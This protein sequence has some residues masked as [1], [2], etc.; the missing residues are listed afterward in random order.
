[1]CANSS[2]LHNILNGLLLMILSQQGHTI[3]YY[4]KSDGIFPIFVA[5]RWYSAN[6]RS[7]GHLYGL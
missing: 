1:M 2:G 5:F 7:G 6:L 3:S 4:Y